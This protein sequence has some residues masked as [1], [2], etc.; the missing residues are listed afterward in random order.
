MFAKNYQRTPT[1]VADL[2]RREYDTVYG[3]G[4]RGLK[5]GEYIVVWG[6]IIGESSVLAY[7]KDA[8]Q[9]GGMALLANGIVKTMSANDLQA[10]LKPKG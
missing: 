1:K 7:E 4:V 8:P 3:G 6:T 5:S 2:T 10:A 9:N